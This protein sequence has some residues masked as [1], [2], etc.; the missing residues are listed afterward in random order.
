VVP[1]SPEYRD[2]STNDTLLAGLADDTGGRVIQTADE[3]FMHDLPAVGAPR[4]I[5]P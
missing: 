4:P 2:L 3:A 5:W 1:Y